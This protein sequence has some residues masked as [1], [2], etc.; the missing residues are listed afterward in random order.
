[1]KLDVGLILSTVYAELNKSVGLFG[2]MWLPEELYTT[3]TVHFMTTICIHLVPTEC[4]K[5]D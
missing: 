3:N 5:P 4:T 2:N 1:L